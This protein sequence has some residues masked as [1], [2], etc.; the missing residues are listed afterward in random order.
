VVAF[1]FSSVRKNEAINV[2]VYIYSYMNKN[3]YFNINIFIC[4]IK[5]ALCI[6][7]KGRLSGSYVAGIYI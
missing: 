2:Y 1:H 3:I 4:V 6:K 5:Y 7:L